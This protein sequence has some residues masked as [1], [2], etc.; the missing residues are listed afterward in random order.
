[1]TRHSRVLGRLLGLLTGGLIS[2]IALTL[3][4]A[5]PVLA[6]QAH[7]GAHGRANSLDLS[8]T[9]FVALHS[10]DLV[11]IGIAALAVC[12]ILDVRQHRFTRRAAAIGASVAPEARSTG[13]P[14]TV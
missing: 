2:S 12:I 11:V 10:A 5:A 14:P 6:D 4:S 3:V 8:T 1:M 9:A 13:L 7:G